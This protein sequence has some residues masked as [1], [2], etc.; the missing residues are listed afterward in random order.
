MT[1]LGDELLMEAPEAPADPPA[2]TDRSIDVGRVVCVS[3]SEVV[4]LLEPAMYQHGGAGLH[5]GALVKMAM[6]NS[7]VF[8]IVSGLSIPVPA[9]GD[10]EGETRLAELELIGEASGDGRFRR[11][12]SAFPA[13]GDPVRSV[14]TDDFAA[15]YARPEKAAIRIGTVH[16]EPTRPV[17][18]SP[19]DLLG[20]HF[21]ILGT[22][23]CGRSCAVTLILHALLDEHPNAHIVMLDPHNEYRHAFGDRAHLLGPDNLRL[24]YWLFNSEEIA[25]V[26]LGNKTGNAHRDSIAAI[27]NELIPAAKR[28][29]QGENSEALQITV[30]TPIPYRLSDVL[31]ELGRIMGKLDKPETLAPY[32]WLK[33]RLEI[34]ATDARFAFMFG[35]IAV[36]DQMAKILSGIFRIPV[37]GKPV[38]VIDLS[39]VPSEVLNTVVS[40]LCR[41]TFDFALWSRG[42][43][44]ILLVCEEAHRYAPAKTDAG[45]E[46][47]K[48]A[49]ARIAK[50]G[51]KYG[52]S[53][54]MISQRPSELAPSVLSQC[55]TTFAFR[56]TSL[57]DQEIARG[58]TADSAYGLMDFLPS[59]GDAEAIVVGEGVSVPLRVCFDRLR[60]DCQPQSGTARFSESWQDAQGDQ[61]FVGEVV[62]RWRRQ[63][64]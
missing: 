47:T 63:Q 49:L 25:A 54:C 14:S 32:R 17:F 18:L 6:P 5:K 43:L 52:V 24:P 13:L 64:R 15:V 42:K 46:P 50:E 21:A 61:N 51:R 11:G 22:T 3:G 23:G 58:L 48:E 60:D 12:I 7:T 16:Q 40:V 8:G 31:A 10:T 9:R 44:P 19:N 41:M 36:Q 39:G 27:L 34:L 26:I 35:G 30:D 28:S 4:I 37:D 62:D 57:K 56:M 20:K 29:F 1:Q 2:A 45:F 59:L 33:A 55:S 38:S 53:L